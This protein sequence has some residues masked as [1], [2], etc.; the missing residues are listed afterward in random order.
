LVTKKE[1]ETT[2]K[3]VLR[4]SSYLNVVD[5][6]EGSS[7]LYNGFTSRIDLVPSDVAREL[8][9]GQG[10]RD[11]SFLSSDEVL[12][13]ANRGHLTGLTISREQEEFR[14]LAEHIFKGNE[15]SNKRKNGKRAIAFILTYKC[16]LSCTY[17]YQ[18]ALRKIENIPSMDEAFVDEF[19]RLYLNKLFPRCHKKNM[20]F[21]LFGGEP[22]LPANR[23]AIEQILRYAKK[24]GI[25]VS[26]STNA[27]MLPN[28]LDLI[29]PED[30][31]IN[32]V[33][34][35]LDGGQVFHD[36]TRIPQS[37]A[38]TFEEI[39]RSIRELIKVKA[40]TIIRVHLHPDKLESTR[41]LAEY[42]G[43][44]GILGHDHV[45]AYFSPINSFDGRAEPPSYVEQFSE[46][47]QN[48]TF[49]QNSPPSSFAGSLARIMDADAM[50]SRLR[51]RY[52][53]AGADLLRVVDSLGDI[54]D[55]YEEAGN[56]ARR[57]AELAEGGV[58]YFK[59]KDT[60]ERR[61][62]LNMPECLKCSIALYCGG[63]CMSQARLQRGS[64]FK[65]L[66]RQNKEFVGQTLKAYFLLNR[67]GKTG[68]GIDSKDCRVFGHGN[69]LY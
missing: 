18:N 22:L 38:P 15:A 6:G 17:C 35:T 16:N 19:F 63:G 32:T 46:I 12:H 58:K 49:L 29:G 7:L 25:V 10:W 39:I 50:K 9:S 61:H 8:I 51:S 26:T 23:G 57:I 13:L 60:Y 37:G 2:Q 65:P 5:V 21:L 27:V 44:E 40:Q 24:H 4:I 54:Y 31:K 59:L 64:I 45:Y 53:S 20:G 36:E 69:G 11:F 43:R 33:Q 66:C 34:V 67:A 55:C 52:C 1:D 68:A 48:V 30:G 47:F 42:L 41:A 14:K 28:M 62:I 3:D 56:K